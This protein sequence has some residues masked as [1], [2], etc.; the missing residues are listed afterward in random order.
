VILLAVH[1][2]ATLRD[3]THAVHST[4]YGETMH[5]GIGPARE[6]QLIH[7]SQ[8]KF[9]E[10]FQSRDSAF[11]IWD[12]GLGAGANA[13]TT[14]RSI[15]ETGCTIHMASFDESIAAADF[16]LQNINVLDY[17]RGYE[18]AIASLLRNHHIQFK[19]GENLVN[20]SV[21]V[22][23]FPNLLEKGGPAFEAPDALLFDPFS[24]AKNPA[25]WTLPLFKNLFPRLESSRPCILTTYSRSTMVR[26][27]LL[28]A[29]FFVGRGHATGLKEETTVASNS[30]ALLN[31]PLC[32]DWLVRVQRSQSAEPLME[33]RYHQSPLSPGLLEELQAHPQFSRV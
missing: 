19:D 25:M 28:L 15:R 12:V 22:G 2:L 21:C 13:V 9:T 1:R 5:P 24:P 31:D 6:A 7:V 10:R 14:L 20:W 11:V 29:G 3:G 16:A 23:D 33:N 27:A 17:L 30:M 26:V 18:G 4:V 32:R 8:Q